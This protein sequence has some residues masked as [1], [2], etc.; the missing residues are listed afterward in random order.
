MK[1]RLKEQYDELKLLKQRFDIEYNKAIQ[2]GDLKYTKLLKKELEEKRDLLRNELSKLEK[3]KKMNTDA[4]RLRDSSLYVRKWLVRQPSVKEES[5]TDWLLFDISE[6][7]K[8]VYYQAFTRHE[9][10]RKTGADWEWWFVFRDFAMKLRIQAKK[11]ILKQ[12]NYP[13]LAHTNRYGLQIEKLLK[14]SIDENFIPLY[15]FYASHADVTMCGKNILDE[16]VYLAG[17]KQI[18]QDFIV[19]GKK[20]VNDSEILQKSNPLSC[21]LGCPMSLERGRFLVDYFRRYYPTDSQRDSEE[22]RNIRNND[23]ILGYHREIPNY[24][25]SF[26]ENSSE[27]LPDWWESEFRSSIGNINALFVYDARNKENNA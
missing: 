16:G 19:N 4:D 10:A 21:V 3:V 26:I 17:G 9:E 12:D 20:T 24:V 14:D 2:T 18:Y 13:S 25:T 6:N 11:L 22:T 15:A 5:I 8:G 7:I 23:E 1:K 27:G